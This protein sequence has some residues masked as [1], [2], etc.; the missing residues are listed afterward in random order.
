MAVC[1]AIGID[2]PVEFPALSHNE[3]VRVL[4]AYQLTQKQIFDEIIGGWKAIAIRYNSAAHADERY[5]ASITSHH[6]LRS[7]D[8]LFIQDEALFAF[9][10]N[11]YA[12][13]ESFTYAV[14]AISALLRPAE[15]R[16]TSE[17]DRRAVTP[18][19]TN[20]RLS[21]QFPGSVIAR[22]VDGLVRDPLLKGWRDV[23]NVLAH[24]AAPS[25]HHYLHVGTSGPHRTVWEILDGIV[26]DDQT[27][28][29]CRTWLAATLSACVPAAEAF[30]ME[31]FDK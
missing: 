24:R 25:R 17:T 22:T 15:F 21:A 16:M 14:F 6:A 19:A 13:I 5:T 23:R 20:K 18:N 1:A 12:A 31:H 11:G 8:E 9:F 4:S 10:V 26:L 7:H 3:V 29:T 28:A 27:T 2:L 30:V